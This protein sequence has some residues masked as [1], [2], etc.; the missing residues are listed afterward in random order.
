[1]K[2]RLLKKIRQKA[3]I[4]IVSKQWKEANGA[5]IA[6]FAYEYAYLCDN[7]KHGVRI[8]FN[9]FIIEVANNVG[10]Y[11]I[12]DMITARENRKSDRWRIRM[13]KKELTEFEQKYFKK[14][15]P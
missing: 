1:M 5:Y 10:I 3:K 14:D 2:A 8:Y 4:K 6:Y 13:K 15:N 9:D 7:G 11:G 12:H